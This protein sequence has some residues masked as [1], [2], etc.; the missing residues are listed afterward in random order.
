MNDHDL[1]TA[2]RGT[3]RVDDA[4]LAERVDR[5]ALLAVRDGI[6]MTDRSAQPAVDRPRWLRRLGR[7]GVAA[8]ALGLTLVGSGA[9]YAAYQQWYTGGAADGLTCMTAWQDPESPGSE[10]TGG[11]A[12]TGDPVEDCQRYQQLS[13]KP[14]IDDAVAFTW[15][16]LT[17]VAPRDQVPSEGREITAAPAD[18]AVGVAVARVLDDQVDG[19]RSRCHTA[20]T[21]VPYVQGELERLGVTGW[22][23]TVMPDDPASVG[24][25][26]RFDVYPATRTVH[27]IP[28]SSGDPNVR[29]PDKEVSHVVYDVRDAL[30]QKVAGACLSAKDAEAVTEEILG[31]EHHWPTTV[32]GNDAPCASVDM[33][34]GGSIQVWVYGPEVARPGAARPVG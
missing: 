14:P 17:V 9:A 8:G 2:V 24:P 19:G 16:G 3:R 30:R 7:R 10:S 15:N 5:H 1:I 13:G 20:E 21:A 32:V 33:V 12:L 22:T 25:C 18:T 34:V 29:L 11:P 26:G 6:T 28:R 4:R 27:F 23:V 31:S